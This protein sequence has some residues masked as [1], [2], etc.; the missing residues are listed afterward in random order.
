MVGVSDSSRGTG[1]LG[2][3]DTGRRAG[4]LRGRLVVLLAA[5]VVVVLVRVQVVELGQQDRR[6]I[7]AAPAAHATPTSRGLAGHHK[8]EERRPAQPDT[9]PAGTRKQTCH[10][11]PYKIP[12]TPINS[13][14][15]ATMASVPCQLLRCSFKNCQTYAPDVEH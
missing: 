9:A 11:A 2:G 5:T 3:P 6:L 7:V 15:G 4:G 10:A 12:C 14:K 1:V 13:T 8:R